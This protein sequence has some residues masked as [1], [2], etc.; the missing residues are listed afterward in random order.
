MK[1]HVTTI[2]S[3]PSLDSRMQRRFWKMTCWSG[4]GADREA[5]DKKE[6]SPASVQ[7]QLWDD[8]T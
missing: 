3:S 2:K 4:G 1:N 8:S 7:Q 5:V 6:F